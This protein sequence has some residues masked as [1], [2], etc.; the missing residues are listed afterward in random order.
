MLRRRLALLASLLAT[1]TALG[2]VASGRDSIEFYAKDYR[3]DLDKKL[4][5]GDGNVRVVI[6]GQIIE[7]DH[8]EIDGIHGRARARGNVRYVKGPLEIRGK[9][10]DVDVK[11]GFGEFRDAVLR[12]GKS[13]VV[14]GRTLDHYEAERYRA[15][16][17]KISLCQDCPQAWSVTGSVID[18]EN[19]GFATVQHALIQVRDNPVSY[20][21]VIAFPVKTRRQS[22]FLFPTF[23]N[24]YFMGAEL[25]QPYF[26]AINPAS[27]ATLRYD[28]LTAGGQRAWAEYRYAISDRTWM[29]G[30][31]SIV[32]SP[33][34][35]RNNE[36]SG[37]EAMRWGYSFDQRWQISREWTQRF[38]GELASDRY[39]S[40]HFPEDFRSWHLPSLRD[41]L[42][43]SWQDGLF[44]GYGTLR[45]HED[46]LSRNPGLA[47]TVANEPVPQLYTG[48][49][50]IHNL[51]DVGF[52][53]PAMRLWK[54]VLGSGDF[55]YVSFRRTGGGPTDPDSDWIR[56]GDRA[57][58][59][60]RLQAAT[61]PFAVAKWEPLVEM[62]LDGYSFSQP[63]APRSAFRGRVVIDQ[64]LSTDIFRVYSTEVGELRAIKHSITPVVRWSYSPD[65]SRTRT[66][67]PF[68]DRARQGDAPQFDLL[69]PNFSSATTEFG[70]FSEEQRL[71]RHHLMTFGLES[72]V[73]GRYGNQV[74]RYEEFLGA[75]LN[76]DFDILANQWGNVRANAFGAYGPFRL[77][78]EVTLNTKGADQ[79]GLTAD[80]RNVASYNH[81]NFLVTMS[82][83]ISPGTETYGLGGELRF[84]RPWTVSGSAAYSAVTKRPQAQTYVVG[85]DGGAS[86]CFYLALTFDNVTTSSNSDPTRIR[87]STW[88]AG[89]LM[90]DDFKMA[91]F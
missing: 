41:E 83:S 26:W 9:E 56:T 86:K 68:F 39:Y 40:D 73:V 48:Y 81:P 62:Q 14:E 71:G 12:V 30:H 23:V 6:D 72:R 87:F 18:V 4:T 65:D 34:S 69:D 84:L 5:I 88:K 82:Q 77:S 90:T 51:P 10:A 42:S 35:L 2:A 53:L 8:I 89:F 63:V 28:Y 31:A 19:E 38:H 44:F 25:R 79:K 52:S 7:S 15:K 64:R 45:V 55:R 91:T 58:M 27:D 67:H 11:T 49:G 1:A 32:K 59:K 17:G 54:S 24:Q 70:T 76:R 46:N 20:L 85:Y 74:K 50:M 57:S 29:H 60:L 66:N 33:S 78:T 3:S 43:L 13:L 37:L 36:I 75:G 16:Q 22:G 80:L 47:A 21:P 61:H